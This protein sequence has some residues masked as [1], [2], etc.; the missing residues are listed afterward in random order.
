[1]NEQNN[2]QG[3][4]LEETEEPSMLE[5]CQPLYQPDIE[6]GQAGESSEQPTDQPTRSIQQLQGETMGTREPIVLDPNVVDEGGEVV[7]GPND[8]THDHNG[9]KMETVHVRNAVAK[10]TRQN[11]ID[12]QRIILENAYRNNPTLNGTVEAGIAEELGVDKV[13]VNVSPF[14]KAPIPYMLTAAAL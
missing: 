12:A 10:K 5:E 9:P 3:S 4:P 11:F 6:W 2:A 13:H 7:R 14:R 8:N 1:L